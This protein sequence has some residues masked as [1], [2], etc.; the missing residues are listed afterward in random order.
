MG[1]WKVEG[2][3]W[4]YSFE[5]YEKRISRAWFETKTEAQK[6]RKIYQE[7]MGFSF[8]KKFPCPLKHY[9]AKQKVRSIFYYVFNQMNVQRPTI[10]QQCGKE[11][12]LIAHYEDYTKPFKVIW[13]CRNCHTSIHNKERVQEPLKKIFAHEPLMKNLDNFIDLL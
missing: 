9:G 1:I 8:G 6:A 2:K 11:R 7:T 12:K 4:R 3:G 13:V 5:A 10:C